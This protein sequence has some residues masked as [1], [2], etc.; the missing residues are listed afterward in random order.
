MLYSFED[1]KN[2]MCRNI[3]NIL[4]TNWILYCL[5]IIIWLH[6]LIYF[7]WIEYDT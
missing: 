1:I 4:W 6:Y 7:K 5:H 3:C 2:F